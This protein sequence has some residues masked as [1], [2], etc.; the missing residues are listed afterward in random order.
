[1]LPSASVLTY[2]SPRTQKA[3]GTLLALGNPDLG[4]PA[5][6]LPGAE[7]EVRAVE[8]LIAGTAALF[9]EA[10]T[11]SALVSMGP[12]YAAIHIASHGLFDPI[13]PLASRLLLAPDADADGNL[14]L[15]ELYDLRLNADLIT[16][17]ACE[18]GLADVA[19]GD[20]LV[21]LTR[22]FLY[23]GARTIIASWW[24]VDDAATA[25]MM[26]TF[27]K[28]QPELGP[29]AALARAQAVVRE[30]YPHPYYWSAFQVVGEG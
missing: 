25:L 28:L 23:A 9:G 19:A 16:L 18:T 5:L 8:K 21:G 29:R 11:E 17:S 14:T 2:L 10:A 12:N 4:D 7:R 26:Q 13:N 3:P 27:Y 30:Q 15:L 22:G 24:Q 1:V 6:A 20:E